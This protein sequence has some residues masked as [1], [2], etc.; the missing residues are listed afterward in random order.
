MFRQGGVLGGG[1]MFFAVV[2]HSE[3]IDTEGAL[4]EIVEQCRRKLGDR[5][6]QA[7]MLFAAIDLEH[8]RILQGVD[9]AWPGLELIGCTTD[10]E[11]SS[12]LGY[13]EDSITL[14]LFGSDCI[15]FAA[16]LGRDVSK[17]IPT[18]CRRA[19]ET[20]KAKSSLPPAICITLPESM[21]TNG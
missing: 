16:G 15:E 10:G 5:R 4:D 19:V 13:R 20:A 18:A 14:V 8:G 7:G 6:P 21:T 3:D 11:L 2:A 1:K 17:D 9:D 12:E